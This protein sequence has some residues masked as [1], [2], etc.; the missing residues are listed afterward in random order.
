MH[1]L[2]AA[3][4]AD[5]VDLKATNPNETLAKVEEDSCLSL[6]ASLERLK[7]C[8]CTDRC[9][10]ATAEAHTGT[11]TTVVQAVIVVGLRQKV[12]WGPPQ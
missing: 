9:N 5:A 7:L 12:T 11:T 4:V 3:A 10:S 1:F 8:W 2:V 6:N